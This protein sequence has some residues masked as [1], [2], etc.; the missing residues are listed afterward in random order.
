MVETLKIY[1]HYKK[2]QTFD[3]YFFL[4]LTTIGAPKQFISPHI[5]MLFKNRVCNGKHFLFRFKPFNCYVLFFSSQ[6]RGNNYDSMRFSGLE[7]RLLDLMRTN[8][9]PNDHFKG[10]TSWFLFGMEVTF[11]FHLRYLIFLIIYLSTL[12]QLFWCILSNI[13]FSP[14]I[15]GSKSL[16]H[17]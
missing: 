11:P 10:K 4:H 8:P 2:K 6:D 16:R 1:R 13:F 15:C 7:S 9:D 3:I 14:D 17:S 5:E 12:C